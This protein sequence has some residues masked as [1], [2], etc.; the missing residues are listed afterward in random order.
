MPGY[1]Q[2]ASDPG[3]ML[4]S[5]IVLDV[6][7]KCCAC[8]AGLGCASLCAADWYKYAPVPAKFVD[9]NLLFCHCETPGCVSEQLPPSRFPFLLFF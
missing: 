6:E 1:S 4:Q 5:V 2:S 9:E 8:S 3:I 7:Q